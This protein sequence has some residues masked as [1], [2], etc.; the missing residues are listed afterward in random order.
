MLQAIRGQAASWIVKLLFVLLIL[1]FM[2]W[3][4]T[5]YLQSA[6]RPTIVAEIGPVRI[7]PANFAQAVA[8]EMQRF[9]QTLGVNFDREQ[10]RQYGIADRV[11]EQIVEHT[12]LELEARRLGV[13]I[14]DEVVRDAIRNNPSFKDQAGNFDRNRFDVIVNR[15][16][17]SEQRF[18]AELR[19]DLQRSQLIRPIASGAEPPQAMADAMLRYRGERRVAD[20]LLVS[21]ASV[22][23]LPAPTQAQL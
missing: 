5:D 10:A 17:Y 12:L 9:R 11:L 8:Q 21:H 3:G 4:V 18:I 2:A 6:S 23:A 15:A 1:S 16:G 7:E 22:R 20:T 14:S 19:R 13:T